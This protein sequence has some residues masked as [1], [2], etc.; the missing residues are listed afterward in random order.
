[1][2]GIHIRERHTGKPI[3]S[4]EDIIANGRVLKYPLFTTVPIEKLAAINHEDLRDG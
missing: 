2:K 1:M 4:V 3:T